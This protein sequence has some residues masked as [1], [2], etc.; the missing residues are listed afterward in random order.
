[1]LEVKKSGSLCSNRLLVCFALFHKRF[2]SH[3]H[4]HGKCCHHDHDD[5]PATENTSLLN[6]IGGTLHSML[7]HSHSHGSRSVSLPVADALFF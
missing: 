7:T 3:S 2:M 6:R 1:M 4:V 5:A